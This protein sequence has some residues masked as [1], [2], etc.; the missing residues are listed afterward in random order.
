MDGTTWVDQLLAG[1]AV[2]EAVVDEVRAVAREVAADPKLA[3]DEDVG[4]D[5]GA[6]ERFREFARK[7]G[8]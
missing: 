7:L 4:P 2:R 6:R 3:E 1:P 8:T 5:E